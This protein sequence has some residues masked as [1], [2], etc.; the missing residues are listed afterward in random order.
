MFLITLQNSVE[1][2]SAGVS[3]KST[4]F[5]ELFST[6]ASEQ[7]WQVAVVNSLQL[8][9]LC[10]CQYY[11]LNMVLGAKYFFKTDKLNYASGSSCSKVDYDIVAPITQTKKIPFYLRSP[12]IFLYFFCFLVLVFPEKPL[13]RKTFEGIFCPLKPF[14]FI[15]T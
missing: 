6:A 4:Y 14:I 12:D 13:F 15:L 3:F 5:V 2:T 10:S 7:F 9:G 1:N 8:I 11:V